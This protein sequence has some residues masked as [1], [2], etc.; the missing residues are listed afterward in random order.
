MKGPTMRVTAT[1]AKN[2][3]GSLCVR[4]KSAP[5]IVE[6]GGKP[7]SV[8]LSYEEFSVLQST[9]TTQTMAQ[10]KRVFNETYGEWIDAQNEHF[11]R[12]GLW[13][14]GLVP[15]MDPA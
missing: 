10:R 12:H 3:F 1:E 6:K 9:R 2:R 15:W 11:E 8:I 7:D 14:D 4:A 13:C 5:V